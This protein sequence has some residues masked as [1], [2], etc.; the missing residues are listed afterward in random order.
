MYEIEK[1]IPVAKKNSALRKYPFAELE[2]NDSFFIEADAVSS[3]KIMTRI[4]IAGNSWRRYNDPIRKFIVRT[5]EGGVR[6]WR[7]A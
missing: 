3:R 4:S 2:I 5:V 6:C 1:G 7:I